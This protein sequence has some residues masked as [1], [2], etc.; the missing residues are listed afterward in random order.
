MC[1]C[2]EAGWRW[3]Y[4]DCWGE[5]E[6][7]RGRKQLWQWGRSNM[8]RGSRCKAESGWK[9]LSQ[10]SAFEIASALHLSETAAFANAICHRGVPEERP[11]HGMVG[12]PRSEKDPISNGFNVFHGVNLDFGFELKG[13]FKILSKDASWG[14]AGP[15]GPARHRWAVRSVNICC[16]LCSPRA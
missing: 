12:G 11:C 15:L 1:V 9:Y 16:N 13:F 14:G 3:E 8:R 4:E 2:A 6:A 5:N 7:K 10:S